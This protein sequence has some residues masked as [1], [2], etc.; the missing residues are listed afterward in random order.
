MPDF[1]HIK[2]KY[3]DCEHRAFHITATKLNGAKIMI[4]PEKIFY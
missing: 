4:S 3:E 1:G 2:A